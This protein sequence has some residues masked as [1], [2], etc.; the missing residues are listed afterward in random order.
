MDVMRVRRGLPRTTGRCE[1]VAGAACRQNA[2]IGSKLIG[3]TAR[4][5]LFRQ[6]VR[7]R[8]RPFGDGPF[9]SGGAVFGV[10]FVGMQGF[11]C[12]R[13]RLRWTFVND[14]S[15]IWATLEPDT[16]YHY[17][18][19]RGK[20]TPEEPLDDEMFINSNIL[21]NW[22][23]HK[24]GVKTSMINPVSSASAVSQAVAPRNT[25]QAKP[26][27]ASSS[28]PKDSVQLTPKAHP[29]ASGDEDHDGDSH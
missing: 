29:Q 14:D 6:Q 13:R 9:R 25:V 26:Q 22:P 5:Y 8:R 20:M 11:T 15:F 12:V 19:Y 28:E 7:R 3:K 23:I 21:A 4:W 1:V 18:L 17:R 2:G 16:S 27:P 24:A 10:T